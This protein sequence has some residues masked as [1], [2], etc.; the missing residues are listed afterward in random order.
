MNRVLFKAAAIVNIAAA[1]LIYVACS[2]DDG[3]DGAKGADGTSC[4]VQ[5]N[6]TGNYDILCGNIVIGQLN[7]GVQGPPGLDGAFAGKGDPGEPGVACSGTTEA[8]SPANPY[9]GVRITCGTQQF[10]VSNGA[11]GQGGGDGPGGGCNVV[12]ATVPVTNDKAITLT[13][14]DTR[15]AT[16]LVCPPGAAAA[17]GSTG[18]LLDDQGQTGVCNPDGT[19]SR[20]TTVKLSNVCGSTL[21][22]PKSSFCQRTITAPATTNL[23]E[24]AEKNASGAVVKGN[25]PYAKADITDPESAYN[26]TNLAA[27]VNSVVLPLCGTY[28]A[29]KEDEILDNHNSNTVYNANS[30]CARNLVIKTGPGTTGKYG[31]SDGPGL[32]GKPISG[33]A[34]DNDATQSYGL[35]WSVIAK[36]SCL[37]NLLE[38][39]TKINGYNYTSQS[40]SDAISR[41][42]NWVEADSLDVVG[43]SKYTFCPTDRP[44][45][46][47]DDIKCIA[48]TGCI[49]HSTIDNTCLGQDDKVSTDG[50]LANNSPAVPAKITNGT[51]GKVGLPSAWT[52]SVDPLQGSGIKNT[53]VGS[54]FGLGSKLSPSAP[55]TAVNN[56]GFLNAGGNLWSKACV[57]QTRTV[58]YAVNDPYMS[59]KAFKEDQLT[60]TIGHVDV[61]PPICGGVKI[62][63]PGATD[64]VT[65]QPVAFENAIACLNG[66]LSLDAKT[67]NGQS[68]GYDGTS[69]DKPL[70]CV[71]RSYG[72]TAFCKITHPTIT[73]GGSVWCSSA[74]YGLD[75]FFENSDFTGPISGI[76]TESSGTICKI[77]SDPDA[78]S[79]ATVDETLCLKVSSAARPKLREIP[80]NVTVVWNTTA[81][82]DSDGDVGD[83]LNTA[84]GGCIVSTNASASGKFPAA[85]WDSG[86][87]NYLDNTAG[88]TA[89]ITN[90]TGIN[91]ASHDGF[92]IPGTITGRWVTATVAPTPGAGTCAKGDTPVSEYNNNQSGCT[93]AGSCGTNTS[94]ANNQSG[95]VAAY[96]TDGTCEDAS[97]D[98]V[99]ATSKTIC[100][101]TS[102]S[103][104]G[105][106]W[107]EN[108]T[109]VSDGNSW[110]PAN[111]TSTSVCKIKSS[112]PGAIS[113]DNCAWIDF[114]SGSQVNGDKVSS[115][116]VTWTTN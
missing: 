18:L 79:P 114:V 53:P 17:E 83:H 3:K 89:G 45:V 99:V 92:D 100:E 62:L 57:T 1:A 110:T 90:C 59:N 48:R 102:G 40:N 15:S 104:T 19:I 20:G 60:G 54:R 98:P 115:P 31:A 85:Q 6:A 101:G 41:A 13:C 69:W 112:V 87:K 75:G 25:Y 7:H 30:Y 33:G 49:Y 71:Q 42:C 11:P 23:G 22:D 2:G 39:A 28:P 38:G 43:A 32:N 50:V 116:S 88:N 93:G 97:N 96:E 24:F 29:T 81:T 9:G 74:T 91:L 103:P 64:S 4:E 72:L 56:T 68:I 12:S 78:N 66:Q 46:A 73:N 65:Q 67:A 21:F 14:A 86:E 55:A 76:K 52:Y 109:W 94:L 10:F 107:T 61:E 113:A 5:P 108:N 105:N 58:Y 95:C 63:P 27:G 84:A 37:I 35:A 51:T 16:V 70:F 8:A 44:V 47:L 106:T 36:G 80:G 77:V 34:G 82:T 111:S 26:S